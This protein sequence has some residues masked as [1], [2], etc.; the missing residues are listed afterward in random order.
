VCVHVYVLV[1]MCV[2]L[3]VCWCA[4]SAV[5]SKKQCCFLAATESLHLRPRGRCVCVCVYVH[6]LAYSCVCLHVCWCTRVVCS[7]R[8]SVA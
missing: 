6:V 4:C 8:H 7:Q 2:C 3:H 1:C 5:C